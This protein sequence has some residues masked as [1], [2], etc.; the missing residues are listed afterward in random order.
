VRSPIFHHIIKHPRLTSL[1]PTG[2]EILIPLTTS[3]YV[4]GQLAS[5]NKV[6]VDVGT[7]FYVE[8]DVKDARRFYEAKVAELHQNLGE[9]EKV[10]GGKEGNLRLVEEVLR[11]KVMTEQQQQGGEQEGGG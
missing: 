8:K 9:I 3:L 2:T 10:V 11:G 4:P 1:T 7:G 5:S 6:L